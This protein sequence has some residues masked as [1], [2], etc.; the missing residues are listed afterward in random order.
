M[1]SLS[2]S[3]YQGLGND[4]IV[5]D[6]ASEADVTPELAKRLCDRHFGVGGDGVLMVSTEKDATARMTIINADGSR[7]EMCGNGLRCVALHLERTR[8]GPSDLRVATDAGVLDCRLFDRDGARWVT[9]S[10]GKAQ[11][12]GEH[13]AEGPRGR[14][15]FLRVSMGNPHAVLLGHDYDEVAIDVL[16]PAVS[17]A[18]PGGANVE[19]VSRRGEQDLHLVVWE[20]GV[21]RT[22]ACGTGAGAT[23]VAA[24]TEGQVPFDRPVTVELPGGALSVTVAKQDLA[25]TL[26]GPAVHVFDGTVSV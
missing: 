20:R 14:H 19:F 17:A 10:L 22:L 7:P 15:R 18:L 1:A 23:V 25:V 3:K 11:L 12:L 8:S 16:G 9:I 4:F 21:G 6:V 13:V 26:S 2:F 24:A 5:V